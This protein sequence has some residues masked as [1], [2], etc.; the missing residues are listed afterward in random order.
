MTVGTRR[1]RVAILAWLVAV[2]SPDAA[3]L[4][5]SLELTVAGAPRHGTLY[6]TITRDPAAFARV[7]CQ[8]DQTPDYFTWCES[9]SLSGDA[10][11]EIISIDLS[12]AT[13]AIKAFVDENNNRRLDMGVLG[14][15]EPM[16]FG[17]D[18]RGFYG[19]PS[20][21]DASIEINGATFHRVTLKE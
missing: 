18:A 20:F 16:A 1:P 3:A 19:P 10:S 8:E 5:G 11:D 2:L 6:V 4:A 17:N 7:L 15:V 12:N 14:P 13:Y 9:R 21:L